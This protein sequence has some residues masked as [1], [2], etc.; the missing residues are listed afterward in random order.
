MPGTEETLG[1]EYLK[2]VTTMSPKSSA[3]GGLSR[4]NSSRRNFSPT[5]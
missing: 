4:R 5:S 2:Q 3:R 1:D